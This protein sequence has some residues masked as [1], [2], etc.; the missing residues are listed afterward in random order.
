MRGRPTQDGTLK[1]LGDAVTDLREAHGLSQED[2]AQ[3]VESD[4]DRREQ[5]GQLRTARDLDAIERGRE[6]PTFLTLVDI[7]RAIGIP[8]SEL[9]LAFEL[10]RR[11]HERRSDEAFMGRIRRMSDEERDVLDRLKDRKRREEEP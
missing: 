7:A 2:V 9:L 1:L 11:I 4:E 5:S 10:R 3:R 8:V 6:N